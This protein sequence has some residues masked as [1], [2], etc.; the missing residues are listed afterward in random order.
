MTARPKAPRT[1]RRALDTEDSSEP[2][3]WCSMRCASTSVSVSD[4]KS[5]TGLEQFYFQSL[6]ILDNP[7]VD[8][9]KSARDNRS[10]G[11]HSQ[12]KVARGWPTECGPF[13]PWPPRRFPRA[14]PR[15]SGYFPELAG[16]RSRH[17][18]TPQYRPSRTRDIQG[19][20]DHRAG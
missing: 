18:R 7:I 17:L 16:K 6:K 10:G 3:K 12:P 14:E 8:Y 19:A 4:E 9:E 13:H 11:G 15:E 5:V 2:S 20:A 1:S